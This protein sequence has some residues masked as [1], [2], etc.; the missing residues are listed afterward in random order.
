[1]LQGLLPWL[2][3]PR[4]YGRGNRAWCASAPASRIRTGHLATARSGIGRSTPAASLSSGTRT[5]SYCA[6]T[7]SNPVRIRAP[8]R[9][10][11]CGRGGRRIENLISGVCCG[12]AATIGWPDKQNPPGGAKAVKD[13]PPINSPCP[14]NLV[15]E[16]RPTATRYREHGAS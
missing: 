5:A 8:W 7:G 1:M 3:T 11:C 13:D 15:R 9:Q 4:V 6:S 12:T 16:A 14:Q 10:S 2:P